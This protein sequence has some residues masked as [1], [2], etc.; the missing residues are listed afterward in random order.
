M[1][2]SNDHI[3]QLK[4]QY[5][6]IRLLKNKNHSDKEITIDFGKLDNNTINELKGVIT[7]TLNYWKDKEKYIDTNVYEYLMKLSKLSRDYSVTIEYNKL[8]S[9]GE[10]DKVYMIIHK[11]YKEIVSISDNLRNNIQKVLSNRGVKIYNDILLTTSKNSF[12]HIL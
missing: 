4:Q 7:S 8:M 12:G 5:E 3:K 11:D 10:D 1:A 9:K 2:S 6:Y